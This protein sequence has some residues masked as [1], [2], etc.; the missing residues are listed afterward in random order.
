MNHNS[1]Q[2]LVY[3]L[4]LTL[5]PIFLW[6]VS[7][8]FIQSITF[9]VLAL[10]FIFS[11]YIPAIRYLYNSVEVL[12]LF[13]AL[14]FLFDR[15]GINRFFPLNH[16]LTLVVLYFF[17][18]RYKKFKRTKLN[19][20]FGLLKHSY[21]ISFLLAF[22]SVT[23]LALWFYYQPDNPYAE[24]VPDYSFLALLPMGIGFAVI[25]ALYEE[26]IFRSILFSYFREVLDSRPALFLQGIW[27][28]FLH[29]QMGFPSGVSGILMT[30]TFG[31]GM[32][33]LVLRTKGLFLPILIHF[34]ADLS[35][36]FMIV[37]RMN[38]TI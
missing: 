14:E 13:L 4:L 24:M 32:G 10:L 23:G 35:I 7:D 33:Y 37:L 19:L 25:N 12:F 9:F 17:L 20:N 2:R 16:L 28:S 30:F 34:L 31:C 15:I 29:Y 3:V 36:F 21:G 8:P 6:I 22:V 26:G 5:L 38:N 1:L 18:L 27:F 11:K